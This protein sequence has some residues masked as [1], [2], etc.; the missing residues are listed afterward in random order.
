MAAQE[1]QA[2]FEAWRALPVETLATLPGG[3][4]LAPDGRLMTETPTQAL[5]LLG[6]SCSSHVYPLHVVVEANAQST[7]HSVLAYYP[8]IQLYWK[9]QREHSP[10]ELRDSIRK[11]I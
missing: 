7:L 4:E 10:Y 6:G 11:R 3:Y 8:L 1:W 2:Q 5:A 9:S